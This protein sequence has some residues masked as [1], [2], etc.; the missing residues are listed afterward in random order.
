[1]GAESM[2]QYGDMASET[3]LKQARLRREIF[4]AKEDKGMRKG[5]SHKV[6][7]ARY[8]SS[9]RSVTRGPFDANNYMV[10]SLSLERRQQKPKKRLHQS[11]THLS[12]T[13]GEADESSNLSTLLLSKLKPHGSPVQQDQ[14]NNSGRD[15][16][17]VLFY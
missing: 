2:N 11:T 12:Q 17:K 13:V 5:M 15:K 8:A 3:E 6:L 14:Y 7:N 1:M 10:Q 16:K 4:S 9:P